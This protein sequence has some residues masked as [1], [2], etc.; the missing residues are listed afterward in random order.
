MSTEAK[1]GV[2]VIVSMLILGLSVYWVTHTQTV[3]GQVVFKTYFR[4]AGGLAPGASVMFGG[5]K[6]GQV[7]DVRP[8][9]EDPTRIEITFDVKHDTAL[10]EN[11]KARAGTVTLMGN[12]ALLVTTGSNDARRLNQGD[13]VQS[14]EAV[15]LNEVATQVGAVAESASALIGDLRQ[16]VPAL[17]SEVRTVVANMNEI[18]GPPNQKRI[19]E[20]LGELN[21]ILNRESPKIAQITDQISTLA[22]HADS[23][24]VSAKP[25][26]PNFEQAVTKAN[27]ILDMIR[28]PLRK[29]LTELHAAIQQANQVLA[30]VQ[31]VLGANGQDVAETVRNLRSASEN[32]RALTET[33]KQ[34]PWN[35]VRTTQPADRKVP[36]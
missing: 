6:V 23:V 21:R 29:D 32:I 9:A 30:G 1:V 27:D 14:E 5:I 7:E 22:K 19:A 10:N 24:V 34:R 33:L 28:E 35:L 13:V 16:E 4:Y 11:S 17:T 12:P 25:I 36:Q 15:S 8:S 31:N 3:K 2:F 26:P 20:S 18:T